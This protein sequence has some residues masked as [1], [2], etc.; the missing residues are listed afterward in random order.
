MSPCRQNISIEKII[1]YFRD[2]FS[3]NGK[4]IY[5]GDTDEKFAYFDE[6]ALLE[7][8]ILIGIHGKMPRCHNAF[9]TSQLVSFN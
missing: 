5:V 3:P 6:P 9:S 2:Q 4:I 7:L 8:G 1:D